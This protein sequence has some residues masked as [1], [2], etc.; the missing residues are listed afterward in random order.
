M[1]LEKTWRWFGFK[2]TVQLADLK[3]I[4]IEGV[5]T[6]LHHIPNGEVWPVEEIMKVKNA[7]EA[8]GMRWSVVESLPVSEGIKIQSADRPRLIKN[9]QES[10]RN[11]GKC[12]IDTVC[13][14]FMPV[15]DWV[16]TDLHY[17][18]PSGGEV[19]YFD[20][21][22][23]VAFDAFILNRPGAENDYPAD[24]VEKAR[25]LRQSMTDDEANKLAYNI[26]IVTQGFIDGVVDGSE[27]KFKEAFL[28]YINTYKDIDKNQLRKHLADFLADVV[29]VAEASGVN[30]CIHPDD[31]PFPVLGLPRIVSTKE[32]FEWIVNQ[33]DSIAN[34]LTFCTG[35]LSVRSNDYLVDIVKSVGH[36]IHFLHLRN[37]V[38]L[39]DGCFHEYGHIHGCVDMYAVMKA[40]LE[41]QQRR[42]KEGRKDIRMP[43]R[44]DHGVKLLDDWNRQSNP[45]Y[46]LIGR[47][48]GLAEL[49]GL[50]M[51][52]ER[53]MMEK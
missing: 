30:L 22:T 17:T 50:E 24:I 47:M 49:T 2:D 36:R 53:A 20:F 40:L 42:I 43:V 10:I 35:S 12:G 31:P 8:H 34:G 14:N 27:P 38:L 15:L 7:I 33:Y 29:P 28:K 16:R 32:D 19:M 41:E 23:F 18:L 39:P 51:G 26:I 13:Y 9:Y 5:V 44:P 46:P 21:P 25:L 45:G 37:N 3:Q 52:I 48:K 11:L 4:G 6:A 1:A